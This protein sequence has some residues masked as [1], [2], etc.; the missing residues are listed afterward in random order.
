M[1]DALLRSRAGGVWYREVEI[2]FKPVQRVLM[3]EEVFHAAGRP[4]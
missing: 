2:F 3:K 4:Y 1:C